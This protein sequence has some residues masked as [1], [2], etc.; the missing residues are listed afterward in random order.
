MWLWGF[1]ISV[2]TAV[3]TGK[4]KVAL[5]A[6]PGFVPT[7][8]R[9]GPRWPS[10][11]PRQFPW[12]EHIGMLRKSEIACG[13]GPRFVRYTCSQHRLRQSMD[14]NSCDNFYNNDTKRD[15]LV[16]YQIQCDANEGPLDVEIVDQDGKRRDGCSVPPGKTEDHS[17]AVPRGGKL[18]CKRGQGKCTWK[19]TT[20]ALRVARL[21]TL[22]SAVPRLARKY[23]EHLPPRRQQRLLFAA[24]LLVIVWLNAY[25]CRQ[26]FFIE[27]TGKMNSMHG[28]W[29]AMARLGG[30]HWYKPTWWP[31]WYNG[32][33]FE[34]TYAPLVPGLAAAIARLSGFSAARAFQTVSG[35]VYCFGPATLFLMARQ[36]TRRAGWSFVAAVV[37]SLSSASAL[38]LPDT[39]FG[40]SALR[41]PRRLYIGFV[42]DELPHQLALALVCLAVLFLARALHDRRFRSFVWAGLFISLA[43]LASAFGATGLLLLVGCLV[44]TCETKTWKRNLVCVFLCGVLGYLAMCP[45]LPPSLIQ[46]IRSNGSLFADMAWTAASFWTL[47]GVVCGGAVLWFVSRNW[48]PWHLRF[49]LLLAYVSFAIP[50]LYEKRGLHFLPQSARYKVEL[51]LA[52]ALLVVFGLALPIDR[53]PKGA[54]IAL[55][56]LFLWPAYQQVVSHRRYS[57]NEFKSVDITKT[58]EY[59]IARWMETDLPGWRV[60]APGS[61]W[62]WLNTF[63]KA[64]QFTGGSFPTAPN[65]LQMRAQ[66]ELGGDYGT[67]IQALWYK[68]YG[69]DAVIVP[70]RD[71]PEFWRPH[72]RGHQFD[73]VFPVVWEERDTR[74]YAVPRPAR[75]LVHAIPRLAVVSQE[76][77][78]LSDTAQIERY[79]AAVE[80]AAVPSATFA[81]LQDSRARIH[82]TL[83]ASQVLSVQVTYHPGWKATSGGRTVPISKDALGLMVLSPDRPG[84]YDVDLVYDGGFESKVCRALSAIILLAV[85]IAICRGGRPPSATRAEPG[86]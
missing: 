20:T 71:S 50:A 8:L 72:L 49:F 5:A 22:G 21:W 2:V 82:A 75:T 41:D 35:G 70:G 12:R 65:R 33:P 15:V 9:S 29:I 31:Y 76:P 23:R 45:F 68:A 60:Q 53:L 86:A 25:I 81:W 14:V 38:L 73:G 63:S 54:R 3:E 57:K 85:T 17:F 6:V 32:T 27:F 19:G 26:V 42:W 74:I 61:I 66:T 84:D 62:P 56:V 36:L 24:Y 58:I 10:R 79:L 52:L 37:Y 34:Y 64:P 7:P 47:A 39:S 11:N 69:V 67:D 83:G 44:V 80:S 1:G 16:T 43:L 51:E 59:R 40:L 77:S 18:H 30:E 48:R 4:T 46:V 13:G 28:F 55:A 78:R